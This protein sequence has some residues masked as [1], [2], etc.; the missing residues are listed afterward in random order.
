MFDS[1]TL[2]PRMRLAAVGANKPGGRVLRE[3]SSTAEYVDHCKPVKSVAHPVTAPSSE[4]QC[5]L[6]RVL[7]SWGGASVEGDLLL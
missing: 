3:N 2:P 4:A 1:L 5:A 6:Q 7:A